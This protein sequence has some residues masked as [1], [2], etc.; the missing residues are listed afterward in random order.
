MTKDWRRVLLFFQFVRSKAGKKAGT[1]SDPIRRLRGATVR[2]RSKSEP[3]I[4]F[5]FLPLVELRK[6]YLPEK[7]K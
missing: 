1:C 3:I 2:S 7:R 4:F 6:N 5:N